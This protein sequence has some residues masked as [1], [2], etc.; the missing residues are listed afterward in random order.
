[1][2]GHIGTDPVHTPA[3]TLVKTAERHLLPR[4]VRILRCTHIR[5]MPQTRRPETSRYTVDQDA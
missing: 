3:I 1:M 2:A 4:P 5:S